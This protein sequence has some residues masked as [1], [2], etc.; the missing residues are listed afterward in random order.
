MLTFVW[1]TIEY[2]TISTV[3]SPCD[4]R[5]YSQK[6]TVVTTNRVIPVN[7]LTTKFLEFIRNILHW[8]ELNWPIIKRKEIENKFY[9]RRKC[10]FSDGLLTCQTNT[11]ADIAELLS[12]SRLKPIPNSSEIR[13]SRA[14]TYYLIYIYY[15]YHIPEQINWIMSEGVWYPA[16]FHYSPMSYILRII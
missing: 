2:N 16:T 8:Y 11:E 13:R 10:F 7:R 15:Q 4:V 9:F 14:A 1:E 3:Y 12:I 6:L 5:S